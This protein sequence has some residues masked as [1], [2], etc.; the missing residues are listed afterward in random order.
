MAVNAARSDAGQISWPGLSCLTIVPIFCTP[1]NSTLGEI[2]G[3]KVHL[4]LYYE[5]GLILSFSEAVAKGAAP[6]SHHVSSSTTTAL[7]RR[8]PR[9]VFL[10]RSWRRKLAQGRRFH[11]GYEWGKWDPEC[12]P[13]SHSLALRLPPHG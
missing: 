10:L 8:N 1:S 5:I 2:P 3:E 4:E 12:S 7:R 13:F 9:T 11:R 6:Y